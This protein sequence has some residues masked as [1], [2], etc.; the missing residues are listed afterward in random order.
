MPS[1]EVVKFLDYVRAISPTASGVASDSG[2]HI[3]GQ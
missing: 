2:R 3:L 1:V